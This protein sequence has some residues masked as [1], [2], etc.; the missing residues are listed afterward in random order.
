MANKFYMGAHAGCIGHTENG[1]PIH[2]FFVV[3]M[4]SNAG[5]IR[6]F[7]FREV[8]GVMEDDEWKELQVIT[9]RRV[10]S[11]D[12]IYDE[13]VWR[14]G[15]K[16][17]PHEEIT[18]HYDITEITDLVNACQFYSVQNLFSEARK[19]PYINVGAFDGIYY[20]NTGV[21]LDGRH[22]AHKP[23]LEAMNDYLTIEKKLKKMSK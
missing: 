4:E 20:H 8:Y 10:S 9:E 19:S 1:Y 22:R 17:I 21:Q 15:G 7:E 13:P 23:I 5:K 3:R 11:D 12:T 6:F 16:K 14:L 2:D 18:V